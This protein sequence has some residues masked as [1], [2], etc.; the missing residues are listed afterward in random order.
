MSLTIDTNDMSFAIYGQGHDS[1]RSD[2]GEGEGQRVFSHP[3]VPLNSVIY[4]GQFYF[5]VPNSNGVM[6]DAVKDDIAHCTFTPALGTAFTTVG[7]TTV[8]VH[9]HREYANKTIDKTFTQTIEVVDHGNITVAKNSTYLRDIY[10][11]GYIFFRPPSTS[12]A[13]VATYRTNANNTIKKC[14]SLPWR[15]TGLGVSGQPFIRSTAL[16]DISELAYADVSQVRFI[17]SLFNGC[18]NLVDISALAEWDLSDLYGI[19]YPFA[20]T[21]I[22]NLEP[23]RH[24]IKSNVHRID[25]ILSDMQYVE[26]YSPIS[27]WDLSNITSLYYVFAYSSNS[28]GLKGFVWDTSNVTDFSYIL[29]GSTFPSYEAVSV[30]DTSAGENFTYAFADMSTTNLDFVSTWDTSSGQDFSYCC[31]GN[32]HLTDISGLANWD[33]SSAEDLTSFFGY[34]ELLHDFSPVANWN[35]GNVKYFD[36]FAYGVVMMAS[37]SPFANWDMSSARSAD[38][39]FENI[40]N[41]TNVNELSGWRLPN[42][43][44]MSY[45]FSAY[46]YGYSHALGIIVYRWLSNVWY[47]S[48]YNIYT[49]NEVDTSTLD[50]YQRDAS[51]AENWGVV[52]TDFNTFNDSADK[53]P[54]INVPSWN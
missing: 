27:N 34:D 26:D 29:Y 40:L 4:A 18:T 33:F 32:R 49:A 5:E 19:Y 10:S 8:S 45:A 7:E 1:I 9:Y 36:A 23:I 15:A 39:M 44:T 25:G 41:I 53:S 43:V 42:L 2:S 54:W 12:T 14:S 37:L 52:G 11:D 24:L 35:V 30:W 51:V 21:K 22:S 38:A 6:I 50:Y 3:Y 16:T 17:Y 47:D 13:Q 28:S 48:N 20:G 46:N 31:L